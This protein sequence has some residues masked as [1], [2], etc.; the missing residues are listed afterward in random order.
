MADTAINNGTEEAKRIRLEEAEA[1]SKKYLAKFTMNCPRPGCGIAVSKI[2]GCNHMR[3]EFTVAR[4]LSQCLTG[5]LIILSRSM[6]L[7]VYVA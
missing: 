1:A 3:C 6:W 4:N 5:L 2:S 7:G